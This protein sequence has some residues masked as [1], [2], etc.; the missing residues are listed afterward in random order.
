M[1]GAQGRCGWT[2]NPLNNSVAGRAGTPLQPSAA[3]PARG[4]AGIGVVQS[5]PRDPQPDSEPAHGFR[6]T[7]AVRGYLAVAGAT[8]GCGLAALGHAR[9]AVDDPDVVI[10]AAVDRDALYDQGVTAR[11][12]IAGLDDVRDA[13]T[14]F[15]CD[16]RGPYRST[17]HRVRRCVS[18]SIT[19]IRS[20][21]Q[22]V[23]TGRSL[24]AAAK[25][26]RLSRLDR[27]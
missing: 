17:G 13:I 14:P 11:A 24:L 10:V 19:L 5:L 22:E 26:P 18:T 23:M 12:D 9:F 6:H 7:R 27:E 15:G 1:A 2:R 4:E 20:V 16:S 3:S 21:T 8:Y 25:D